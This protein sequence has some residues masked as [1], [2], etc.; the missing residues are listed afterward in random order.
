MIHQ[1]GNGSFAEELLYDIIKKLTRMEVY[2]QI[3][4]L[5]NVTTLLKRNVN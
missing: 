1:V 5:V 4:F 2:G 3:Y